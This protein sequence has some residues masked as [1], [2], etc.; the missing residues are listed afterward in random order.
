M[1]YSI[2]SSVCGEFILSFHETI[3][4]V[5]KEVETMVENNPECQQTLDRIN[6]I[7]LDKENEKNN[8]FYVVHDL[9]E[10]FG[11]FISMERNIFTSETQC[12]MGCG[13]SALAIVAVADLTTKMRSFK[14]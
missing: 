6:E 9:Y 3:E 11:S 1:V 13:N 12:K 2:A 14:F 4:D 8:L 10:D 7:C 5:R